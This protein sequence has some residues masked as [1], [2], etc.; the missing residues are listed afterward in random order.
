MSDEAWNPTPPGWTTTPKL[1]ARQGEEVWRVTLEG[2]TIACE[3]H[4]ESRLGAGWDVAIRQDGELSFSSRCPDEAFARFVA[5]G[6]RQDHLR[7]GWKEG[8]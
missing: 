3:L 4:D 6:L 2:R 7:V 1:T 8:V 5:N